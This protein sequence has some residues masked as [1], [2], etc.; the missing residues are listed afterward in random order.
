MTCFDVVTSLSMVSNVTHH[1]TSIMHHCKNIALNF[2]ISGISSLVSILP[3]I[4]SQ[5]VTA[6]QLV[7]DIRIRLL[8]KK[9]FF[10][11]HAPLFAGLKNQ[12]T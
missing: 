1:F 3:F 10:I 9:Y 5:E 8:A 11:A 7:A 4:S 12:L 6:A 2:S